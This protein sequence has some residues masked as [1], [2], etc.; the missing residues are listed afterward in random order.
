MGDLVVNMQVR[1]DQDALVYISWRISPLY[2]VEGPLC[3]FADVS[4][5]EEIG[6]VLVALI[7]ASFS[8]SCI[9]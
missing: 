8:S 5:F 9:H 7:P 6:H 2:Y 3:L 4:L 1:W